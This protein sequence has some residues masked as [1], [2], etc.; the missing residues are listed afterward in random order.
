[1]SIARSASQKSAEER[2]IGMRTRSDLLVRESVYQGEMCWIVKDPLAMKYFR[3]RKPEYLIF[4]A[5]EGEV[6]YLELK[7]SL[8]REFPEKVTRTE[9]VQQLVISLH[10]SGLLLSEST[11]QTRPLEKRRNKELRQKAIGLLSSLIA[12]RLPGFD[13]EWILSFLYPKVR[14][15]FTLWFTFIVGLTCLAAGTLVLT[16]WNE[17]YSRLPEFQRFFAFENLLFMGAILIVTKTIH[18]FGHGLMCKH[19]GGECH[20]IGF[21]L[22]VLTPAMYC[23]TSDSWVMPNRWHRIAIGAAGMYVEV[24]L[25]AI[26]TFVWWFTNPGWI[27]YLALNIMFLSSVSTIVFNANPLLRYDGYFILSDLLEIPNLAQKAKQSLLSRLRVACLGMKPIQ[28][29]NMPERHQKIFAIYS[30][31]SFVYRW[32]VMLMIFWFLAEIFEPMGLAVVGHLLIGISLVGMI[33][34]PMYKLTKFFLYPGRFREVKKFRAYATGCVLLFAAGLIVWAP[35]PHFVW[36]HFVVRPKNPQ[37]VVV[38][39]PGI[40]VDV[41][42]QPGDAVKKGDVLAVLEN[43]MLNIELLELTAQKE[44]LL[45]DKLQF[46]VSRNTFRRAAAKIAELEVQISELEDQIKLKHKQVEQLVLI[47]DRDGIV[48]PPPN[49]VESPDADG[50]QLATWSGTPMDPENINAFLP[51]D[52]KFCLIAGESSFETVVLVDQSDLKLVRPQQPMKLVA[53]QFRN[54]V[55]EGTVASVAKRELEELP[56]EL[57]QTNGG[58]I[59]VK[60]SAEGEKP[61]LNLYELKG[62]LKSGRASQILVTGCYGVGKIRVGSMSLGGRAVRYLQHLINFR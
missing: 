50:K 61:I 54:D 6:S 49:L 12:L 51:A 47:A 38:T 24:F 27:H 37:T 42:V 28:T 16:N 55:L 5:L 41:K 14:W 10:R 44:Q 45:S 25:A 11:G 40:L 36:G 48:V 9:S 59:A 20:E 46:M 22:L 52:T 1:M 43:R 62:D 21:M 56:R 15:F 26:C 23:N 4:R 35:L 30:V 60:P 39:Q 33:V 17:F 34:V 3:L 29:G 19:F 8:D 13:P 2:P 58:P 57:S 7:R 32:F 31:A 53:Q 18:E